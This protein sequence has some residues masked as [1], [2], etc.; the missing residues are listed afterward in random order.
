MS[1][2]YANACPSLVDEIESHFLRG[3]PAYRPKEVFHQNVGNACEVA[4][5]L[6]FTHFLPPCVESTECQQSFCPAQTN[7]R[8]VRIFLVV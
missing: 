3:A 7:S 6:T 4:E 2:T 5:W 8:S 1:T